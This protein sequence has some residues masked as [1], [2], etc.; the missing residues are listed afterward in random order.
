MEKE[1]ADGAARIAELER[2]VTGAA[3]EAAVAAADQ[4]RVLEQCREDLAAKCEQYEKSQVRQLRPTGSA[5]AIVL[6]HGA[7]RPG[8][9]PVL[10]H[11]MSGTAAHRNLQHCTPHL[12]APIFSFFAISGLVQNARQAVP[13]RVQR[14]GAQAAL[15]AA[16]QG[17]Q[18]RDFLVAAHERAGGRL[19]QQAQDL[20]TELGSTACELDT[21]FDKV[22]CRRRRRYGRIAERAVDSRACVAARRASCSAPV[23]GAGSPRAV[24]RPLVLR[25]WRLTGPGSARC[26]AESGSVV[27]TLI[28]SSGVEALQAED[29]RSG[30]CRRT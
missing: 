17:L 6:I 11:T 25:S 26:R 19:A 8:A 23:S 5:L 18:E 24:W 21:V 30:F 1:L 13:P 9:N 27:P 20:R 3:E 14:V 10:S 28:D 29:P 7:T 4:R 2:E 22:P 15:A 16:R 12:S